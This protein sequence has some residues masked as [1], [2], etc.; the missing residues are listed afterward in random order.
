MKK[1]KEYK[2]KK[3]KIPKYWR[4]NEK[5]CDQKIGNKSDTKD[6]LIKVC[7][8]SCAGYE[9]AEF[10]YL[11]G[12]QIRTSIKWLN[13]KIDF[14]SKGEFDKYDSEEMK[15]FIYRLDFPGTGLPYLKKECEFELK[16]QMVNY[17]LSPPPILE[18]IQI[19]LTLLEDGYKLYGDCKNRLEEVLEIKEAE[20]ET[21][22]RVE[23]TPELTRWEKIDLKHSKVKEG[24]IYILS[25]PMTSGLHKIGFT[26]RNPDARAEEISQ[27]ISLP[28][29][30]KV[31]KYWR[32]KDPYIVEQKI[33]KKLEDCL[34]AG[35]F[36]KG[37]LSDL[38]EVIENLIINP[39]NQIELF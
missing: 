20:A 4:Y 5:W 12:E 31:E 35:E 6:D 7:K 32:T 10:L 26:A 25:N 18:A 11:Y 3:L 29:P 36:F 8:H 33:H 34:T 27:K 14:I 19:T 28:L 39:Q 22:K 37:S 1:A 24:F 9:I 17:Q 16:L 21:R 2:L 23:A 13:A 38:S 30:F 15:S